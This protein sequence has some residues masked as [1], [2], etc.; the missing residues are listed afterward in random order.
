MGQAQIGSGVNSREERHPGRQE[1]AGRSSA[2]ETMF[3]ILPSVLVNKPFVSSHECCFFFVV[4]VVVGGG[5]FF[6]V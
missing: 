1:A 4:V 3:S 2:L 5:V 6:F